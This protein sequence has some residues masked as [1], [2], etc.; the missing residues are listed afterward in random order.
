ML[1]VTRRKGRNGALTISG[2]VKLPD[3]T[4]KR[5]QQRASSDDWDLANEEAAVLATRYLKDAWHRPARGSRH[6]SEAILSYLDAGARSD[7]TRQRVRRIAEALG[8]IDPPLHAVDQD[9]VT[10][11]RDRILWPNPKPGTVLREVITPLRA[12]L[13][14]AAR[15]RWCDP[16]YFEATKPVEARTRFMTP[17]EASAL[18]LAAADHLQ[19]LIT[20]LVCTG[21][22]LSESFSLD[23]RD[24][25]IEDGITIIWAEGTKSGRR[26]NVNLP[27]RA[28]SALRTLQHRSGPVF[29]TPA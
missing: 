15:R 29:R 9:L 21:C 2:T 24:V 12:V 8:D 1:T 17:A 27:P 22:R 25:R 20:F 11:L 4:R 26:R 16:P 18:I 3:G 19:S 6:L 14:H 10:R 28:A 7:G 13:A 5:I 23:W